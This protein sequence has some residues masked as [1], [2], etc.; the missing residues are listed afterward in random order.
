MGGVQLRGNQC[1][2]GKNAR[3]P[4]L[5]V[6]KGRKIERR[7]NSHLACSDSIHLPKH[8]FILSS[9]TRVCSFANMDLSLPSV[10]Q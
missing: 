4:G 1:S 2:L 9:L 8:W 5:E 7:N 6:L 3:S 10:E